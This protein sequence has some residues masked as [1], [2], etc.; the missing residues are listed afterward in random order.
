MDLE[1]VY[2][3][4]GQALPTPTDTPY[5]TPRNMSRRSSR[6]GASSPPPSSSPPPLPPSSGYFQRDHESVAK[7]EDMSILDPRRFTPNLHASL[8]SEILS[9]RRDL[10][11]KNGAIESLESSLQNAKVSY[12]GLSRTLS[13]NSKETRSL[14]RQMQLL[15]GGTASAL[16]ELAKERD[17]ALENLS[18][19]RRR[20]ETSQKKVRNQEEEAD[21]ACS[22]WE[23]EKEA[24]EAERRSLERK[25]H[26]A[27]SRLNTVLEEVASQRVSAEAHQL[28]HATDLEDMQRDTG[29]VPESDTASI[30]SVTL[31]DVRPMSAMSN[32]SDAHS[33]RHSTLNGPNGYAGAKF[34]GLSLAEE[35]NLDEVDQEQLQGPDAEVIDATARNNGVSSA[36]GLRLR[37]QRNWSESVMS[38]TEPSVNTAHA[39]LLRHATF[40]KQE[41]RI[42]KVEKKVPYVDTGIQFS[43]PPSPK[44]PASIAETAKVDPNDDRPAS[45]P[46]NE[47]NQ[48]RKRVSLGP[49]G[50]LPQN[51]SSI[52]VC[53]SLMV[54]ASSQTVEIPPSPPRTPNS[55]L[56]ASDL[57]DLLCTRGEMKCIATQTD[58]AEAP[59]MPLR[60]SPPIPAIAIH[61]PVSAPDLPRDA[62]AVPV[63]SVACQ[64]SMDA[65]VKMRSTCMQT[66]GIRIDNRPIRLP[67]HLL[68]SSISSNP[69]TPKIRKER[70][71]I[72]E[73]RRQPP[74]LPETSFQSSSPADPPS[75]PPVIESAIEEAYP[76]NNDNG[77]LVYDGG[78]LVRRPFRISSLF[79]GFDSSHVG[80]TALDEVNSNDIRQSPPVPALRSSLKL[81]RE[82]KQFPKAPSPVAELGEPKEISQHSLLGDVVKPNSVFSVQHISALSNAQPSLGLPN[83]SQKTPRAR[84]Y[85]KASKL[86]APSKAQNI[87]RAAL[88]SSGAA[89]HTEQGARGSRF[90]TRRDNSAR[91]NG[92]TP[93]FPVPTRS[94]SRKI[95]LSR[96]DGAQSPTPRGTE[97]LLGHR[98]KDSGRSP[99]KK[100]NIRK[101][102]SAAAMPRCGYAD[103]QRSRSP[104]PPTVS[105]TAPDSPQLPPM[106]RDDITSSR[107]ERG[108]L[109]P[110]HSR[111][112]SASTCDTGNGS[113]SSSFR[114]VSVV[115]AIAQTMVGEWMWKYV[116]RGKSF[117]VSESAQPGWENGKSGEDGSG[118]GTR[119]KRWVWLAPYE[120]AV[121]WSSKQPVSGPALLGKS[122][123]KLT[124]TSVLDVKDETRPKNAGAQ[125]LCNRSIL[126]LT[127]ARALK[128]TA[129]TKERHHIWLSAL[130]FL[131]QSTQGNGPLNDLGN[132]PPFP[133]QQA[134][135]LRHNPIRDSIRVAKGKPRPLPERMGTYPTANSDTH[136]DL[137]KGTELHPSRPESIR[138]AADPPNVP[139]FTAHTH[140]RKRS[141]TGPRIPPP[142]SILRN[143]SHNPTVTPAGHR[144]TTSNATSSE[145]NGLST[146][147]SLGFEDTGPRSLSM[148]TAD[149]S[150]DPS[151]TLV[152]NFFDAVGTVRMEA[153]V[154]RPVSIVLE[155]DDI[156]VP[157]RRPGRKD[158]SYWGVPQSARD[159]SEIDRRGGVV[160]NEEFLGN[161]DPFRGF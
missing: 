127:P 24:W 45:P 40:P 92:P 17:E 58:A 93:P 13:C 159:T 63:R 41:I 118:K 47:A 57:P 135:T 72:P 147:V 116:R 129:P 23:R 156:S 103:R 112:Q 25:I 123:R 75:S 149:A 12:D 77:P 81:S 70:Q 61:P 97:I 137:N 157:R 98:R 160:L 144:A 109:R 131:S 4:A 46:D 107:Y 79:A 6:H 66:E 32:N 150:A 136:R 111:H 152:N 84:Q 76:G 1:D 140:G 68:P 74:K 71:S 80:T 85:D 139:R 64:T 2:V 126:I 104:P 133:G 22:S 54:S 130:A 8:V 88:I 16:G 105:S 43:P 73:S 69:P 161:G 60:P 99:I 59:S 67:P 134:S 158:M 37:H 52:S 21:R 148:Q 82:G 106:P 138:D 132:L 78:T 114:Q 34:T 36:Q 108:G 155:Q 14:K 90:E 62:P 30:R 102:R 42:Y 10:E 153:F 19:F 121:M 29:T 35:L 101:V 124:I 95:P 151:D 83:A 44:K 128:F 33:L 55:P 119:H 142:P 31:K 120:R 87:R 125:P 94:S 145:N 53:P 96:S 115:D 91:A 146:S 141:S 56:G 65:P 9:L 3:Y 100:S 110:K 154:A 15:E 113:I 117:G 11:S 27:E 5:R 20:L 28:G 50:G 143:F 18:E 89:A 49:T 7:E 51:R 48:R 86:G 39:Q 38:D 26:A 122:G